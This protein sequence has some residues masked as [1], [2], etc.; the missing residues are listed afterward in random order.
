MFQRKFPRRIFT[1]P[2]TI[3]CQ[4]DSYLAYGNELG[5]GG[6]S[7]GTDLVFDLDKYVVV[8]FFIH[9]GAFF[10]LRGIIKSKVPVAVVS[11]LA[12]HQKSETQTK[13]FV[14]GVQFEEMDLVLKRKIRAFVA[15]SNQE[16]DIN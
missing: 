3:L 5:E 6:V 10:C 4:G 2:M 11:K 15:R 16:K 13:S 1:K 14:Y 12:Q 8:S 7:F 9:G